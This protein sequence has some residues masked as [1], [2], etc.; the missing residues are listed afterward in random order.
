MIAGRK[1]RFIEPQGKPGRPFNPWLARW[2]LL[3][4]IT[5]AS[6][7]DERGYDAAVYNENI[8]G[9]L[10]HNREAYE[11]V[12]S[13]DV[14][15]I[16]VM[17]PTASRGYELADRIK[18]DAPSATIV[19]GGIHATLMPEE[20]LPHGDVVVCGE[21]EPVIEPIARGEI[22]SGI[23]NAPALE[24]LDTIPTLNHALMRDFDKLVA[25]FRKRELY[26]LPMMTSR[27]CPHGCSYCAVTRLFGRKVRRQSVE[28]VHGDLTHY[29]LRGFRRVFFYDDNFTAHRAWTKDLL[30]RMKSLDLQFSAQARIDFAWM[31]KERT[32]LDEPL[33]CAM[34]RAGGD[35]L[36]IGYETIDDSTAAE[37][38]KGYHGGRT[39]Q[40]RL[41][42][43]TRILHDNGF[44]IH[45]MFML[46]PRHTEQD[47]N[48]IVRFARRNDIE[49]LQ[50]SVLTPF[51]G[52]PL[53]RQMEPDLILRSF[54]AD[55]DYYDGTHCVYKHGRLSVPAVQ[56]A[57]LK[58]HRKFYNW[59][60]LNLRRFRALMRERVPI[61]DKLS[62]LWW[63]A[64]T[65]RFILKQWAEETSKF[66][67][68][69]EART[70]GRF[71]QSES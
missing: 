10:L 71:M 37:W 29:A 30:E 70:Q 5:L 8:S 34:K 16:S 11:D 27:G 64:R 47:A 31:D 40:D 58:A 60:G 26:T 17:T 51:P 55:W 38:G 59:S 25:Q 19:F 69:V 6:V 65:A 44:W 50:I 15:G 14:V 45:S 23:I 24:D 9:S 35:V 54:P 4:P 56:H 67:E 36:F 66:L 33:L 68:M 7:L 41:R 53:F 12:C 3:G 62:M 43:D 1:I 61:M 28:K 49:S 2:P 20:A 21:G 32:R 46:G 22:R 52:T 63:H 18:Q 57:L 48:D 39:L 13:S 42:Q